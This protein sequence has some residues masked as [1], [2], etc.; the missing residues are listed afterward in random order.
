MPIYDG[1][2]HF[3]YPVLNVECECHFCTDWRA[4]RTE[5]EKWKRLTAGHS[6]SCYCWRC[7]NRREANIGY[8]ASSN[9][10]D[11]YSELS[12]YA[13]GNSMYG[14]YLMKWIDEALKREDSSRDGW[15]STRSV[16]YPLSH[17]LIKFQTAHLSIIPAVSGM[18]MERMAM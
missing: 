2:H 1:L 8:S 16:C 11:V 15:W 17:F 9:K 7:C 5:F 14:P 6:R 3:N 13:S 4:K 18:F 10:R 12:W